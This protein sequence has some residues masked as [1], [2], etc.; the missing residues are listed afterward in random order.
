MILKGKI[1]LT[2]DKNIVIDCLE[3][4]TMKIIN[5]DEEGTLGIDPRCYIS[6]TIL[7]PPIEAMIAEVDGNEEKYD[8]IYSSYILSDKVKE[9]M[10]SI[11][12]FL[13]R[14]GNLLLYYPDNNYNNTVKKML[15]FIMIHYGI[16]IGI[17]GDPDL[18]NCRCYYDANLEPIQ[19]DLI[20]F[21]TG[22]MDWREYLY[23]YPPNI[24]NADK[25]IWWEYKTKTWSC[26]TT[27]SWD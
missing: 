20:Y 6:G 17:I 7:L 22:I 27:S 4:P 15:F 26:T 11:L 10:A 23:M 25:S 2:K 16:H 5:L 21:Y 24:I 13:Y 18:D 8:M 19:L 12:A 14:G 9:Y 1:F 3:D